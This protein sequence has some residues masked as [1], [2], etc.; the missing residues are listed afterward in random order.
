VM[1][2]FSRLNFSFSLLNISYSGTLSGPMAL[3]YG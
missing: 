1:K 2:F 3:W